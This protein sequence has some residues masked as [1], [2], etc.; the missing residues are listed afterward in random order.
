MKI[1]ISNDDGVESQGINI[2]YEYLSENY[3]V[4]VI[5]PEKEMSGSGSSIT[6]KRPLVPRRVKEN[7]IAVNGTPVDC[8]HLGLHELCPFKPDL[9]I[10]GINFGANMAEDLLYSGTVG[11]AMEGREMSIPSIAVS[12][13]GFMQP[14][15]NKK[16]KPNFISAAKVIVSLI[17]KFHQ[18]NINSQIIL[19]VNVPNLPYKEIKGISVTKLGS[20]GNRNP[21]IKEKLTNGKHQF[22]ISHRSKIPE[23]LKVTDISTLSR[24]AVSITPIGPN[25]LVEDYSDQLISWVNNLNL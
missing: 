9:L 14:G 15:S 7:F 11:A 21:P 2:L 18:L 16:T 3:E 17:K 22:W 24:G 4:F 10:T 8:V 19:N 5:A 13:A 25:F 20:W 1:M 6:T 23:N 12:A